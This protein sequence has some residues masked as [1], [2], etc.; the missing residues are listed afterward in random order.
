MP[1]PTAD[2][3]IEEDEMRVTLLHLR[4]KRPAHPEFQEVLDTLTSAAVDTV[5]GL[6]WQP[7]LVASA[8]MPLRESVDA[9]AAADAVIILGGEDVHPEFYD[10]ALT[11]PGSGEHE[12]DADRAHIA[13]IRAAL[14][15]GTP[16]LGICR[17][18]QLLNV[19]LGGTLIPHLPDTRRHRLPGRGMATFV[20]GSV[21]PDPDFAD[22]VAA[23]DAAL[24]GHHQA[25][26]RL[27]EGLIIAA[28]AD[29]GVIEAVVHESAPLT[30]VQW[31]PEHPDTAVQQ[32]TP[33][34][35]RLE[36]QHRARRQ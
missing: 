13:V 11:Y 21:L 4:E 28:R 31:H 7:T 16:L 30:G 20:A 23:P 32:L 34:L 24:C 29:D 19:A 10:G 6:G 2:Q 17:G 26:D 12:P 1:E 9:A 8:E 35:R 15:A 36:R 22:D 14:A 25:I 5:T 3:H 18:N 27:G 33:L